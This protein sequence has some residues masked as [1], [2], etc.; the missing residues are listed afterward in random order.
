MLAQLALRSAWIARRERATADPET[1]A[2]AAAPHSGSTAAGRLPVRCVR[3]RHSASGSSE[4]Q[5]SGTT[6]E[7]A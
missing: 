1:M 3:E 5:C 2:T 4:S 7:G 6:A